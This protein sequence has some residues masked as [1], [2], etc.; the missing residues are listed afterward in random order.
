[1]PVVFYVD[2][3]I[4]KDP[5][6]AD[7]DTITLSYTFYRQPEPSRPYADGTPQPRKLY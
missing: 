5:D 1:M 4:L 2:P 3:S 7:I 6:N